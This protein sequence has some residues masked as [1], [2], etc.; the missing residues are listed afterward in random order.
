MLCDNLNVDYPYSA[1]YFSNSLT[2]GWQNGENG[3]GSSPT[4][5]RDTMTINADQPKTWNGKKAE[6]VGNA[7]SFSQEITTGIGW[8]GGYRP[9]KGG[10]YSAD[11][12]IRVNKLCMNLPPSTLLYVDFDARN[13]KPR[14]GELYLEGGAETN[15]GLRLGGG[16]FKT[17]VNVADIADEFTIAATVTPNDQNRF[18]LFASFEHDRTIGVDTS[19]GTWNIW[20]GNDGWNI[21]QADGSYNPDVTYYS[22]RSQCK[23]MY[24]QPQTVVYTHS[25]NNWDLYVA[26]VNVL[27]KER[28]GAIRRE[29]TLAFNRWGNGG[30]ISSHIIFHKVMVLN[31]ALSAD[32]M[33]DFNV[34]EE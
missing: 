9:V 14:L 3:E 16:Y 18:A 30:Y 12:L 2:S 27:H 19:G 33:F 1:H 8:G 15:A 17:S 11:A 6:V 13:T 10:I 23:V 7:Y 4:V 31:T 28:E 20:A 34:F 32:E 21:L 26:G 29:G 5:A 24:G 22:G 25:G